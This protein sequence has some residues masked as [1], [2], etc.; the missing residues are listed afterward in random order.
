MAIMIINGVSIT[1]MLKNI[2]DIRDQDRGSV[3]VIPY[4]ADGLLFGLLQEL[5]KPPE[6]TEINYPSPFNKI[7]EIPS[8]VEGISK[9]ILYRYDNTNHR[10]EDDFEQLAQL[11]QPNTTLVLPT[12]G[13]RNGVSFYDVAFRIFMDLL[14]VSQMR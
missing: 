1:V 3:I 11:C 14:G 7:S 2:F 9:F 6:G 8:Y 13:T 5:N 10:L 12:F 4:F